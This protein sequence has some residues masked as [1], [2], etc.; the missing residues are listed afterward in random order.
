MLFTQQC[1]TNSTIWCSPSDSGVC[2]RTEKVSIAGEG[3]RDGRTDLGSVH[4]EERIDR[5]ASRATFEGEWG[6]RS[7]QCMFSVVVRGRKV[8]EVER[9]STVISRVATGERE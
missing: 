7:L 8:L 6:S 1:C 5:I 2:A 3:M 9:W 4:T